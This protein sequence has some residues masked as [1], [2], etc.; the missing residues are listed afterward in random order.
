MAALGV[1]RTAAYRRVA[2]CVERGLL[3]RL[4]LLRDEPRLL[5]AT[6][7]GLRYAGL[8][9]GVAK[10]SP[11][12]VDHWLRCAS[13]ALVLTQEFGSGC[14]LSER[15]LRLVERIEGRPI[16]SAKLGAGPHGAPRLHRPDLVVSTDAGLLAVEVELT[17][18]APR[19]LEALIR[20][21]RRASWVSEI[22]YYCTPGVTR[23]ALE[24]AVEKTHAG[25]R[26]HL[27]EVVSRCGA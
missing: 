22:R 11:G 13:T 15:E 14:V 16:A 5:R 3:E 9:L 20:A 24:R 12:S 17:P 21:W 6:R 26:V 2:A 10:V 7:A 19:R 4:D 1:G 25:D 8:G 23:R 18:K 27:L